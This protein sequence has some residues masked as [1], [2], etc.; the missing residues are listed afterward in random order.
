MRKREA[1][2]ATDIRADRRKAGFTLAESLTALLFAA[3]SGLIAVAAIYSGVS[4]Y[5]ESTAKANA[6]AILFDYEYA[7][8]HELESAEDFAEDPVSGK[9]TFASRSRGC[10]GYL[11]SVNGSIRF[12]S[13]RGDLV[14][15]C[16]ERARF[17]TA[18]RPVIL[19]TS[20]DYSLGPDGAVDLSVRITDDEGSTVLDGC[21]RVWPES[22][23]LG[24]NDGADQ[25]QEIRP[26]A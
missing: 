19:D 5:A 17:L 23:I 8:M 14:S 22:M 13:E 16:P 2:A 6:R 11:E 25:F 10:R 12:C 3:L 26:A 24:G 20:L 18:I 4:V 1:S 21:F 7:L 9:L 15:L